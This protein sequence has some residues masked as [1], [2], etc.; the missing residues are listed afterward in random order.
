MKTVKLLNTE[1]L[2]LDSALAETIGKTR[3][4]VSKAIKAGLVLVD[5]EESLVKHLVNDSTKIEY[6][7]KFFAPKKKSGEAPAPLAIIF[8]NEEVIVVDK[9][10]GVLVHET[11]TSIEPTL[12]DSLLL[13]APEIKEV[14][15]D[16]MRPGIVHRLDKAASGV[17]IVA[18]TEKAFVHL[19]NQFIERK[20]TKHYSVL[21]HGVMSK[22]TET[23][24]FTIAR[25]K[26]HGRMAAKP[27]SQGGKEAITTYNVV[28][29]YP[30]HALL[31]IQI[32]TGR[33][34]QIRA[35]MFA[36]GHQ[37]A[38]DTLYRI[39]GMKP[40]DIGRLFLHARELTITLPDGEETIFEAPLPEVLEQVLK[41][42]PKL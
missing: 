18:K 31:D 12:V 21:V 39:R 3:S 17:M 40:M 4:Q 11:D 16:A 37:V 14:G 23:I 20:T 6:D 34:H 27:E 32:H 10:A 5:G 25:A 2:R 7:E 15:D 1:N 42:I 8:E 29:Q 36:L 33:T 41:D 38:G 35:H 30:H 13:H 19:K 24:S 9:P 26:S 22:L 28:K